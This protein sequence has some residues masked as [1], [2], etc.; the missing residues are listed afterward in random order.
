MPL[1]QAS[2]PL[3]SSLYELQV[4]SVHHLW[5]MV[6]QILLEVSSCKGHELLNTLEDHPTTIEQDWEGL[7]NDKGEKVGKIINNESM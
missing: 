1:N 2:I 4:T 3:G 6:A 5:C 7:V